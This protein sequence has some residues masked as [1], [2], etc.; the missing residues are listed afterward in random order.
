MAD[1]A[2]ASQSFG[3]CAFCSQPLQ[4]VAAPHV[5]SQCGRPQPLLNPAP[6]FF[7]AFGVPRRFEQDRKALEKRFYELSRILHPDRFSASAHGDSKRISLERMSLLNQ[8]YSTLKSP[9]LL[10]DYLL[11]L[12]GLDTDKP[13]GAPGTKAQVPV[14]LAESWFELQDAVMDEPESARPRLQEFEIELKKMNQANSDEVLSLEKMYDQTQDRI[15]LERLGERIRTESYL[16]SMDRDVERLK[17][18]LGI[19]K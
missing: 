2:G 6:D 9:Q 8:A 15:H 16:R 17:K 7:Q 3:N 1:L 19:S 12:E 10:R 13:Q 18:T 4:G 11:G 14:E 5:C